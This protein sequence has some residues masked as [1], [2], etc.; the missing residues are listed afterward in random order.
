M[1]IPNLSRLLGTTAILGGAGLL[2]AAC[3][4][5][6]MNMPRATD[7]SLA[8]RVID[9]G[10]STI[11]S[12]RVTGSPSDIASVDLVGL[13]P[14]SMTAGTMTKLAVPATANAV[15]NTD[16]AVRAPAKDGVYPVSLRIT[17][18]NGLFVVQF[19]MRVP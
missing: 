1:P 4:G 6:T 9:P 18:R 16:V 17:T 5:N 10:Q 7:V 8:P 2:L 13:P 11:V 19:E 3:A 14:N 12:Y 15:T